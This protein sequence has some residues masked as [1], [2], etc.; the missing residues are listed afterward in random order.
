MHDLGTL[1]S[2]IIKYLLCLTTHQLKCVKEF[3]VSK[4]PACY[5][6]SFLFEEYKDWSAEISGY[7]VQEVRQGAHCSS[8]VS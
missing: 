2:I 6:R 4:I 5:L 1:K 8:F 7:V 3:P